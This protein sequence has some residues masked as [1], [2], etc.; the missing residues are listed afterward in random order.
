MW[1]QLRTIYYIEQNGKTVTLHPGDW[2]DKIG[3]QEAF[4]LIASGQAWIPDAKQ[5]KGLVDSTNG[6]VLT[7]KDDLL[8]DRLSKSL[9]IEVIESGPD[10]LFSENLI[11]NPQSKLRVELIPVG[12]KLLQNWQV[13]V[14]I[15]SYEKL[16][17]HIGASEQEKEEV[18]SVIHELRVPVKNVDVLFIRRCPETEQLMSLWQQDLMEG[19]DKYLSF[20]K[21]FYQV[22]P[23]CCDLPTNWTN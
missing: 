20:L 15:L 1:I 5:L 3:K 2:S 7:A 10:L 22:K 12:F 6:I 17:C 13:A 8:K 9:S 21:R 11:L 19:K 14:P 16:A 18:K 4:R 23:L